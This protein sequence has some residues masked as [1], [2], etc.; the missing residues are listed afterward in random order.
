MHFSHHDK[1][2]YLPRDQEK[3]KNIKQSVKAP[4][5]MQKTVFL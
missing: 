4:E 1:V 5:K 2:S 3:K